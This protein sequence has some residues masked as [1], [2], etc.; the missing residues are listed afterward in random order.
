MSDK[1]HLYPIRPGVFRCQKQINRIRFVKDF[2][3]TEKQCEPK[4]RAWWEDIKSR[5]RDNWD[6]T[7]TWDFFKTKWE[8]WARLE[9]KAK[10]PLEK[11]TIDEYKRAFTQAERLISPLR[12]L[13]DITLQKLRLARGVLEDEA[14]AKDADNY[15]PNKFVGCMRASLIWAMERGYM[16]DILL[17]NFRTLPVAEVE[18]KTQSVREIELL[19]KYGSPKERVVILL[20]FDCGCRPEEI[21]N[22]LVENLD[23][24]NGF[25]DITPH[26]ADRKKGIRRWHPKV[27]KRRQIRL[28]AR[29]V[30]EIQKLA[31][32]GPYLILNQYG[33]GYS[34]QGFS[35]MYREFV[36]KVNTLIR[37]QEDNPIKI[38]GTCKTLRKDYSTSRQGKGATIEETGNSMGHADSKVTRKNYTDTSTPEMKAQ[39]RER[40]KKMDQFIVP[41]QY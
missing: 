5:Y 14:R 18:V 17:D 2:Y 9:T 34:L 25:A 26:E 16:K 20:G 30:T 12:Y 33:E 15:G 4:A 7:K 40:L 36:K 39:E 37:E 23:L 27:W 8:E 21:A 38:T 35:K 29:L 41:L 11:R 28:T 1:I 24:E 32:K 19:L 31:S 3:G 13:A 22:M 10:L 6:G